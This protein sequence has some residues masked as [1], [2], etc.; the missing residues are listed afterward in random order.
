MGSD[1]HTPSWYHD[2]VEGWRR[3]QRRRGKAAS[4]LRTWSVYLRDLGAF[5]EDEDVSGPEL[6]TREVLH[7]WQDRLR[8]RLGPASQQVAVS[9]ARSLLK[10][11]DREELAPRAGLWAWLDS[12]HVPESLP[13]ALEPAELA[14]I[15][16]HYSRA[17]DLAG[18]RDRALFWFLCTS[19][20]RISEG[21]QVDVGQLSGRMVV[22]QKGGDQHVLVMSERARQWVMDYLRA[23]GPDGQPALWI[24]IGRRGRR[25]LRAD[26]ANVIW[27]QLA[28]E[29]RVTPFTNHA[30]RHTM[31]TELAEHEVGDDDIRQQA[32]WA[33]PAMMA[34]YRKL[35]D[36]RRQAIVDRLDDLVPEAT[37]LAPRRR[38]RRLRV[39]QRP[40]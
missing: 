17:R 22:R 29:L 3:A 38:R 33:S 8:V 5:L 16:T 9:A 23:R 30:L 31:V 4:S 28:L 21:L 14:A 27:D 10:W 20:A 18:L 2:W 35:R 39:V 1:G 26:Q 24:H 13:R 25:R 34:R 6:L 37:A 40:A 19:G 12:P 15:L 32:G 7:R 36:T 11:V